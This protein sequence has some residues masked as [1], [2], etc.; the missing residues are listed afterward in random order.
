MVERDLAD[1]V[2]SISAGLDL[3]DAEAG[4]R[5]DD[6]PFADLPE[7]AQDALITDLL[8]GNGSRRWEPVPADEFLRMMIGLTVQGYYGDP[9]NG[10]NRDAVSWDMV[11]YRA[12]PTTRLARTRR[13]PAPT[14]LDEMRATTT[15]PSS[16]APGRAEGS[17]R[18]CWPRPDCAY[19]GRAR[20]VAGRRRPAARP[21]AQ[22]PVPLGYARRSNRRRTWNPRVFVGSAGETVVSP[23]DWRWHNNAM[24][25][26]GGTRVYGAQAWR[27]CPEDF[28]MAS[29]YGV[30]DGSSLADWPISYEDL[31]PDYDRAEWE[32]GVSGDPAGNAYAGPRRRGYPMPPLAPNGTAAPL[33]RGAARLGLGTSPVPLLINSAPYNGRGGVH[34]L[35][36]LR[37]VRLPRRVQ[38]RQPQHRDSA[39]RRDRPLRRAHRDAGRARHHRRRRAGTGRRSGAR[40]TARRSVSEMTADQVLL[41]AGAIE[42]ARLL[43]NSAS[44]GNPTASATTTTRSDATCRATSTPERWP[45]RRAGTGLPRPGSEHRHQRL[46]APQRRRRRRRDDRQRLRAHAAVRL[47]TCGSCCGMIPSWGARASRRCATCTRGW[48]WS[49]DRCR[50]RRTPSRG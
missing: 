13:S 45:L 41:G 31:E 24:M 17:R 9:E 20:T 16:W 35:R 22:P 50:R 36:G 14:R 12:G 4:A 3:L 42:T 6:T 8:A 30:P 21:P 37:R 43:L 1:R 25:V 47:Y 48:P 28:R 44:R 39:R 18:A 7:A 27:F 38:D 2:A 40:W 34:A 11:G 19:C 15:T 46:P 29:T 10:G 5:H 33:P 23:T 32:L 49:W 26:G